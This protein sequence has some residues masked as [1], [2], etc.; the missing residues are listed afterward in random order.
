MNQE[1]K[2]A[3]LL[4]RGQ[5]QLDRGEYEA[6]LETYREA[7]TRE[8]ETP[9]IFYGLGIAYFWLEQYQEAIACC[10][11]AIE[12]KPNCYH[13][14]TYRSYPLYKLGQ[15]QEAL[16]SCNKAIEIEPNFHSAWNSRAIVLSELGE[17]EKALASYDKMIEVMGRYLTWIDEF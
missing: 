10:D 15:Y 17:H 13:A 5:N 11:K 8:R 1:D 16:D 9:Q 2:V 12:I 3:W 7:A 14:W 4:E 6:A